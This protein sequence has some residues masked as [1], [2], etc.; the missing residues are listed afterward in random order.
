MTYYHP[1]FLFRRHELLKKV[2]KGELFLEIGP[3]NLHLSKDLL[4][5][6]NK[7][8]LV[9][10]NPD[11]KIIHDNLKDDEKKSLEL[12]IS[13]FFQFN[14]P[15]NY[16]D[17]IIACE[18]LE[19]IEVENLFLNKIYDLLKEQ[20]QLILSVPS[21]K[22]FFSIDDEVVG[23]YRRY[24]KYEI[25]EKLKENNFS[26]IELTS[27]GY[28]FVNLLRIARI[29][30][31]KMEYKRKKQWDQKKRSQESA[32]IRFSS[33]THLLNLVFNKYTFMPFNLFSSI[34]NN[35]DLSDG[36]I[37]SAIKESK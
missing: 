33:L 37:L 4:L 21:R 12:V 1:R 22:K 5:F 29:I 14:M 7:G 30:F 10:F 11:V 3:G 32:S 15:D 35:M 17:C 13:D 16:Y 20:G 9:E 6:F 27:Y 24:E 8:T 23:H 36:Y 18:V 26:Q 2:R 19:H 34:F 25:I 31:A 28:P